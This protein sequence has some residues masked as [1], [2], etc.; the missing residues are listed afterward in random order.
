[1]DRITGMNTGR[2]MNYHF[3]T[4]RETENPETEE[5]TGRSQKQ[6]QKKKQEKRV[7]GENSP[8]RQPCPAVKSPDSGVG[9][10]WAPDPCLDLLCYK[11]LGMLLKI[12]NV[13]GQGRNYLSGQGVL[14]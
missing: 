3:I 14:N 4:L 5:C 11:P 13:G 8:G 9:Q 12:K 10:N 1:M 6:K 7:E 2:E